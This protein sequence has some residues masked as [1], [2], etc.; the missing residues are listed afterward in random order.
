MLRITASWVLRADE[1][2]P[3]VGGV[4]E[5]GVNRVER[6]EQVGALVLHSATASA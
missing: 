4:R 6:V 3:A 1:G 5:G 2:I